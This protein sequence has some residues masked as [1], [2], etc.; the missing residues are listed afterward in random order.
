MSLIINPDSLNETLKGY[1]IN[2]GISLEQKDLLSFLGM[3]LLVTFAFKTI[4]AI[5]INKYMIN[6]CLLKACKKGNTATITLA[7]NDALVTPTI[8]D[9]S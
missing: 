2:F 6:F 8:P 9:D 3:V 7:H 5:L 1:I 4:V